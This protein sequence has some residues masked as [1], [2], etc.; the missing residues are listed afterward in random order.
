VF[1][2]LTLTGRTIPQPEPIPD[3]GCFC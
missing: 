1:L 2:L 3:G